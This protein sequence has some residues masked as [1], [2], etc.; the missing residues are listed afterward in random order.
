MGSFCRQGGGEEEAG[1]R[2]RHDAAAVSI[3]WPRGGEGYGFH[4][5]GKSWRARL[6]WNFWIDDAL[7]VCGTREF[8]L[9]EPL[10]R[11]PMDGIS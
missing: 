1:E 5:S 7:G 3:L 4:G 11:D 10:D 9:R 2:R 6:I 8:G